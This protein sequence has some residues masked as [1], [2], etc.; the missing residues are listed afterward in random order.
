MKIFLDAN[1]ILDLIDLDRNNFEKTKKR[2][3]QYIIDGALLYTSCDIFTTVYYIASKKLDYQTV[4][5]E[6]EKILTI[7]GIIP[8]D[9]D[10]IN[11]SVSISKAKSHKDLE[12]ILQYVCAKNCGCNLIVTNDKNF[13]SPNIKTEKIK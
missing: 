1:I 9:I 4:I 5:S 3:A 7:V 2:I 10:I 12:D 11:K 13:Y 6:L 8:I